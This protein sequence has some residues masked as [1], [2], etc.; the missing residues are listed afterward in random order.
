MGKESL[1]ACC[2]IIE[3]LRTLKEGENTEG[4][5]RLSSDCKPC[6][7]NT[8]MIQEEMSWFLPSGKRDKGLQM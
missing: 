8:L 5:E 2:F 3:E 4:D 6:S 7:W 1:G